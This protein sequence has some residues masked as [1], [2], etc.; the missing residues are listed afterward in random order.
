M[1]W[2]APINTCVQSDKSYSRVATNLLTMNVRTLSKVIT[3]GT[4]A[5]VVVLA[6]YPKSSGRQ[7]NEIKKSPKDEK[8]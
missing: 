3:W 1:P 4:V 5:W 7:F 6:I 8:S 2:E